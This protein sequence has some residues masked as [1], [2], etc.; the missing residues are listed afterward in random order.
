LPVDAVTETPDGGIETREQLKRDLTE[1]GMNILAAKN[2]TLDE[3]VASMPAP[4][5][6]GALGYSHTTLGEHERYRGTRYERYVASRS[7]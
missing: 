5:F 6:A 7:Q 2:T 4:V 1:R 3:L